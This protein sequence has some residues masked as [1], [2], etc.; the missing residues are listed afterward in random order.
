MRGRVAFYNHE[1]QQVLH[2]IKEL[3]ERQHLPL[4]VIKQL[5]EIRAAQGDVQMISP[6]NSVSC[7]RS[8]P[9]RQMYSSQERN[10]WPR[11]ALQRHIL[12]N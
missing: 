8:H 5:L 2:I 9:A 12:T 7:A 10:C 1:H 4:G 3:K 6:S 11:A